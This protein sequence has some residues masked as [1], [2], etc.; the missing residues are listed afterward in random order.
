M[1]PVL[2]RRS[3]LFCCPGRS[4]GNW[5]IPHLPPE[6]RPLLLSFQVKTQRKSFSRAR[7]SHS[8]GVSSFRFKAEFNSMQNVTNNKTITQPR[9][10]DFP[11]IV[12]RGCHRGR[13]HISFLGDT[14]QRNPT[15]KR[16]YLRSNR[17]RVAKG[18][19]YLD[20]GGR[21]KIHL[22]WGC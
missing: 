19:E 14:T 12:N 8:I 20:G 13:G 11:R 22:C 10:T 6:P 16:L 5:T 2:R 1:E 18:N 9:G 15:Q 3:V 17:R 21:E 7:V 4:L